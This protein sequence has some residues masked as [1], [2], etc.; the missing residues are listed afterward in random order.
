MIEMNLEMIESVIATDILYDT[1]SE[2]LIGD[3]PATDDDDDDDGAIRRTTVKL[4]IIIAVAIYVYRK[5][6]Q[7]IHDFNERLNRLEAVPGFP[8][9]PDP[10]WLVGHLMVLRGAEVQVVK[11]RKRKGKTTKSSNSEHQVVE[12]EDEDKESTQVSTNFVRGY[13]RVYCD[14]ADP[15]TG[16]GSFWFFNIPCVSILR[17]KDARK[18]MRSSSF[19]KPVWLINVHTKQLLGQKTLLSLMNKEWRYYRSAVHKSF[20]SEVINQSRPF[21]YQIGNTLAD[22]LLA[23][24]A[25]NDFSK[26]TEDESIN[27]CGS[28]DATVTSSNPLPT[29]A[30]ACM[31][32]PI[33]ILPL[34]KMAT[35]D[36]FGLVALRGNGV[37]FGCTRNLELSP[38]ASAFDHLTTEYTARLKR[39]WDPFSFLY[40][41]P[42]KSNRDYKRKRS[43]IRGFVAEQITQTRARITET[44]TSKEPHHDSQMEHNDLLTNLIRAADSEKAKAQRTM[45]VYDRAHD[46]ALV[47]ILMTLLFA[48][49]DTTSISLTYA[50]YLL[51][52]NPTKKAK[53]LAEIDAVLG[54]GLDSDE[55]KRKTIGHMLPPGPEELPYTKGVILEALRLFPPVP[56]TT[57]T[58]EKPTTIGGS[59]GGGGCKRA[60]I[61]SCTSETN[62]AAI[63]SDSKNKTLTLATGQ[64]VI[65]PIWSIQRSEL[66]Y[67]RPND[68]IPERWVRRKRKMRNACNDADAETI[69][70]KSRISLWEVRPEDDSHKEDITVDCDTTNNNNE[71]IKT[72][73]EEEDDDENSIPPA[74][75]DAFCSF[76][77]GARNCVGKSLAFDESVILLACLVHK[78]SFELVSETYEVSPS[79]HA[80]LQ[81]PDD[82]LPLIVRP[83]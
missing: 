4:V 18:V 35:I 73:E 82:D 83:R 31:A 9:R 49:Y 38:I 29:L 72:E 24:I 53:C 8:S 26:E 27:D 33:S 43:K 12:D 79:M 78:L 41:L 58:I 14:H 75:R 71:C 66:N 60:R 62:E 19:R 51:A 70:G 7:M 44:R 46:E 65:I 57:R 25:E 22:A 81:Q 67:P 30:D 42:T 39:P 63:N 76:A 11:K 37:D 64:M 34:M 61:S 59:G 52:K 17:G 32:G 23:K 6:C 21:I 20:T 55:T 5:A 2:R 1:I 13:Q 80:V 69:G 45:K 48:G 54:C 56:S 28:E 36:V 10:H 15:G 3:H 50:L 40:S 74:N 68:M 16:M 47:D 77:A